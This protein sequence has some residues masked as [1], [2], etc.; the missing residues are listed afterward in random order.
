MGVDRRERHGRTRRPS[1]GQPTR[2]YMAIGRC[3]RTT[4]GRSSGASR[5]DSSPP[6]AGSLAGCCGRRRAEVE[7]RGHPVASAC[8]LQRA[9]RVPVAR[10]GRVRGV[11]LRHAVHEQRH[12]LHPREGRARRE[13]RRRRDDAAWRRGGRTARQ[14]RR[15]IVDRPRPRRVRRRRRLGGHGRASRRGR[16]HGQSI[17]PSVADETDPFSVVARA[18]HVQP[19]QRLASVAANRALRPG[20][21]GDLPRRADRAGGPARCDRQRIHRAQRGRAG[22]RGARSTRRPTRRPGRIGGPAR[23]GASTW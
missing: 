23:C 14:Q 16:L 4:R 5:F 18:R 20:M 17:D 2:R 9:L 3:R 1:R 6:M 8:R 13:G 19:G 7:D 15:R 11:R 22:R 21:A 10:C 12:G